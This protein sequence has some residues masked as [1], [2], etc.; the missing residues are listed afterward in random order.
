[1]EKINIKITS[2]TIVGFK[3]FVEHDFKV[4]QNESGEY[5]TDDDKGQCIPFIITI[6][7]DLV[8][9][10]PLQTRMY[11]TVCELTVLKF[12]ATVSTSEG[13]FVVNYIFSLKNNTELKNVY[14]NEEIISVNSPEDVLMTYLDSCRDGDTTNISIFDPAVS[15]RMIDIHDD[16]IP[17]ASVNTKVNSQSVIFSKEF[18]DVLPDNLVVKRFLKYLN[19]YEY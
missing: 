6:F 7:K 4:Y 13:D 14:V 16:I 1:M 3:N 18:I 9:R 2:V 10:V 11:G 15:K 8:K 12:Y 17:T 5:V 19:E